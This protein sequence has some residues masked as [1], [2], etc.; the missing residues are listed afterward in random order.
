MPEIG[1]GAPGAHSTGTTYVG[2][3]FIARRAINLTQLQWQISSAV[4][5]DYIIALYQAPGGGS[6]I[7]SRI[8][9]VT[10]V[11]QSTGATSATQPVD[12]GGS[13][14][15]VEGLYY[16]LFARSAGVLSLS[17]YAG[18]N[19]EILNGLGTVSAGM[20][21]TS[22]TTALS[23]AAPATFDPTV[24][25]DAVAAGSGTLTTLQHRLFQ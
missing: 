14:V 15:L 1:F 16:V 21:P 24:G 11:G 8:A 12:G 18:T 9:T 7:A 25:G 22:F 13:I 20:H 3:S 6:G 10:I 4:A 5:A 17:C 23:G 19:A 2:A